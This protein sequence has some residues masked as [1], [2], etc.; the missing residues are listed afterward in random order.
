M[1]ARRVAER[2]LNLVGALPNCAKV[3][4]DVFAGKRRE[5]TASVQEVRQPMGLLQKEGDV[6]VFISPGRLT[7]DAKASA[8]GSNAHAELADLRRFV[9]LWEEFYPK[10]TDDDRAK[11]PLIPIHLLAPS[12]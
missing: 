2:R 4:Y 10:L 9:L 7:P 11:L 6:G 3:V 12:A 8:R 5:P 1:K